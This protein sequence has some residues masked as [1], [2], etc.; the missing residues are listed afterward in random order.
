MGARGPIA[1]LAIVPF[2]A[3]RGNPGKRKPPKVVR[4]RPGIPNPPSN[5]P[6]EALAEWRRITKDLDELGLVANVDRAVLTTYCEWWARARELK[7]L[8][9][10]QSF[11]V[12]GSQGQ[13]VA[14]PLWGMHKDAADRVVSLAKELLCSPTARLRANLPE[15]PDADQS[16]GI[17]D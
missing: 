12:I 2:D 13:P 4:A 6:R 15:E 1:K 5:L 14:N 11:T 8:L 10:E 17:L 3:A 16:E 9:D 7:R